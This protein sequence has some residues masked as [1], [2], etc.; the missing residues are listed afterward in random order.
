MIAG[1]SHEPARASAITDL[2]RAGRETSRLSMVFRYAIA[3]RLGLTV[4]DLECLDYLADV[5][6]ATAGQVAERTN[7]TTGAVTSMLR[8]LQQAGYVTAERDPADRRRVIVALRPERSAELKRQYERFAEG[9]EQLIEGYSV[10]EVMLL[11]RHYDRM[12]AM[13]LA[14]LDRLRGGETAQRSA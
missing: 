12:Q 1:M 8:R 6:S 10:E 9:A 2:M 5:G 7:L 3:E 11:V 14:E 4:S 13:Y